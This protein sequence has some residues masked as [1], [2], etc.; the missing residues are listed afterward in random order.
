MK[1][2]WYTNSKLFFF[3]TIDK[4]KKSLKYLDSAILLTHLNIHTDDS[5]I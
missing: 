5:A 2:L 3:F 4:K 1:I